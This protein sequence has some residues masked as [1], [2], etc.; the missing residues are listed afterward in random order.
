MSQLEF[1]IFYD[2]ILI[3]AMMDFVLIIIIFNIILIA[4]Q[5][6]FINILS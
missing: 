2:S 4:V 3:V 1:C 5:L 6:S